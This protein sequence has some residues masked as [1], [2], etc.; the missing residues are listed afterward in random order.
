MEKLSSK[1]KSFIVGS[2]RKAWRFYSE[3]R[4]ECL[5][6]KTCA[7]CNKRKKEVKA[8]HIDPVGSFIPEQNPYLVRMFCDVSNLQSLCDDC[9][10][11]K[12]AKEREGRKKKL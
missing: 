7:K 8:D 10:D 3:A 12:T 6:S 5:K 2:M 11:E 9:H 4:R 1:C